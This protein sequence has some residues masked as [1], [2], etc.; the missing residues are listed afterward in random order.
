MIAV[1]SQ[2]LWTIVPPKGRCSW[3][4]VWRAMDWSWGRLFLIPPSQSLAQTPIIPS[5]SAG[6][7]PSKK[8]WGTGMSFECWWWWWEE[9]RSRTSARSLRERQ[10]WYA[11]PS[12][13]RIQHSTLPWN[14]TVYGLR[15]KRSRRTH[16]AEIQIFLF[17]TADYQL[18]LLTTLTFSIWVRIV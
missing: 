3:S 4:C 9:S 12:F 18:C 6:S 10:T 15:S 13:T 1:P 5:T 11:R 16:P 14:A 8:L 17:F 7:C 2:V